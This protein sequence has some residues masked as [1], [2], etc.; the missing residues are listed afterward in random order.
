MLRSRPDKV[1]ISLIFFLLAFG[2]IILTSAS[3]I[4]SLDQYETPYHYLSHQFLFGILIGLVALMVL[5]NISYKKLKTIA[6]PLF[7]F[8]IILS[9]LV[10]IPNLGA[11]RGGA[12]RWLSIFGFSFQPSELLKL[13]FIVLL[14]ALLAKHPSFLVFLVLSIPVSALLILQ[15]DLGTLILFLLIAGSVYI[16][17]GASIKDLISVSVL[18]LICLGF[19]IFKAKYRL[20]RLLTFLNPEADP[21]GKGYQIRQALLAIGS[22]GIFGLGLGQSLQKHAYLPAV[23]NDSIFAVIGEELGLIGALLVVI[24]FL[25]LGWRGLWLAAK[26]PDAFGRLLAVGITSWLVFQAFIN[27]AGITNLIPLTGMPLP[28]ISYGSSSMVACLAGVGVLLSISKRI[29]TK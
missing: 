1:L 29:K 27:I 22:G 7:I 19:F 17:S 15:S 9:A 8:S 11:N 16:A 10:F 24:I 4:I 20:N 2:L 28:F 12:N 23:I 21:L 3:S 5:A 25:L 14:A 13:A 6:W 26:A 18:G